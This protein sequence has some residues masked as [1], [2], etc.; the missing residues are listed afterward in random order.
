MQDI[1][2]LNF[3]KRFNDGDT[4]AFGEIVL[5]YQ[6]RIY[7]LCRHMLGN[8]HDAEDVAQDAFLKAY[9]ALPRFQPDASLY[10]WLYRIATNTCIDYQRKPVF[11]SLFRSSEDGEELVHDRASDEPSPERLY[12]SRQID[13]ALKE[14]LAKL[15]PKLRAIII[16]K[17]IEDLSYEEIAETLDLSLGTVKSRIS[18]ARKELQESMKKFREQN[19][20]R[21]V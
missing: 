10:T 14:S 5:K 17:E 4:P 11:E 3:I 20:K 16:L 9:Q 12:Q 18:R 21:S 2:D 1:D 6:D 13:Q 19:G 15:S 8:A 7:N